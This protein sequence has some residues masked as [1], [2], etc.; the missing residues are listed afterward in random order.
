MVFSSA[1]FL[2]YF[3]P[4]FLLAYW[5][6]PVR[7]KNAVALL[8]SL[9][10]YLWGAPTFF[11]LLLTA[12]AFDFYLGNGMYHSTN[13]TAKR[14]LLG[15]GVVANVGMLAYFK[16][17]NFFV[18]NAN[19]LLAELGFE[20][21]SWAAIALPIG[22]SFFTFQKL[23]Y[24]IDL[25]YG[26][27]KPLERLADYALYILLFPQLIAG[28]IV[29]FKEIAD[30]IRDRRAQLTMDHRLNGLFRFSMGLAKKVLIADTLGQQVDLAFSE[31]IAT[32]GAFDAWIA[33]LA[34]AMQI[35][36]DFSGYSDMAIGIGL[37]LGFRL[38]ENF[39]FPYIS[40]S[41]TEFWRRWH[42]TLSNWMRDYL[43][44]PLGG[45][46]RSTQRTYL[47]LVVVFL[48]SGLW[49]GAAWS[50]V[51][52]GLFHGLFL[53]LDRLFLS[54][55]L[56]A[57]G[58]LPALLFTFFVTLLGWVL[59]RAE[60]L[61]LALEYYGVLFSGGK[62]ALT[63]SI[64]FWAMLLLGS[65][66]ALLPISFGVDKHLNNW[67]HKMENR[68]LSI[69]AILTIILL[70]LCFSEVVVAGYNPFIYFRF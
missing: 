14:Q 1:I 2:F 10:F 15:L 51:L 67:L 46:R 38:P 64:H 39:N 60:S 11:L 25:Y 17:A 50:F 63:Y 52:W 57:V 35:Y 5:L 44:I 53:I 22:I 8:G 69:K 27:A 48:L 6:S 3:L 41:I 23:S 66:I 29:R 59:F 31:S 26:K 54:R 34:Y 55:V 49:H 9:L 30:Q 42:I 65:G 13:K 45:N 47:N 4:V 16:Y 19:A 24:L 20:A 32:L 12:V 18:E 40:R 28:P 21:V 70:V 43:Y 58:T 56:A 37:M 68:T 61:N 62:Q 7:F 36:Y 33:I